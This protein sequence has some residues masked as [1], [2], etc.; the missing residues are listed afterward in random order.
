MILGE[1]SQRLGSMKL[2]LKCLQ[3]T[4][5]ALGNIKIS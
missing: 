1:E 4:Q 3:K 2:D 5:M